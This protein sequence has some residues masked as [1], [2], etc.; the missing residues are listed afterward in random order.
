MTHIPVT[1]DG[2]LNIIVIKKYANKTV[3]VLFDLNSH[4]IS[5][6]A[7]Y[8]S[9]AVRAWDTTFDCEQ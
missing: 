6:L 3:E 5:P 4:A 9:E 7:H 2:W 1:G 8:T